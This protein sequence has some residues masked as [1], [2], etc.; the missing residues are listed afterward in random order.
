[1]SEAL[2]KAV[3][4]H[5]PDSYTDYAEPVASVGAC[6]RWL[7]GHGRNV[8]LGPVRTS[9]KDAWTMATLRASLEGLGISHERAIEIIREEAACRAR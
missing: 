3:K 4:E 9:A 1:M 6:L 8:T 5:R 7:C 2:V